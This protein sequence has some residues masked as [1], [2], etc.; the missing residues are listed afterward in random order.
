HLELAHLLEE[1][2]LE[3]DHRRDEEGRLLEQLAGA[4]SEGFGA[5]FPE[6]DG[7]VGIQK[8]PHGS[9]LHS[10]EVS[11]NSSGVQFRASRR[12]RSAS[13]SRR[14][15]AGTIIKVRGPRVTC[16]GA[17]VSRTSSSTR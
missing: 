14:P 8:G 10:Q 2:Q 17:P 6:K 9:G 1:L 13:R 16:C 4:G 11:T 15:P 3:T 12:G 7:R 5:A